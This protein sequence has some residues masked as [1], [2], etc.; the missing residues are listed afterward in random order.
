MSLWIPESETTS[1]DNFGAFTPA[2][3][4]FD[5]GGPRTFT[6]IALDGSL[7]LA[8]QCDEEDGQAGFLVTP[9]TADRIRHLKA[10]DA[11]IYD[12]LN[13]EQLWYVVVGE[14]ER[15]RVAYRIAFGDVPAECLPDPTVTLKKTAAKSSPASGP[16]PDSPLALI[17]KANGPRIG[18]L[19]V[20]TSVVK[21]TASG[22]YSSL[23]RIVDHLSRD[24]KW[25]TMSA[26]WWKQ[27]YDLPA[28]G[29]KA[30]SFEI[31]FGWPT[32]REE[33]A[34]ATDDEEQSRQQI[35]Q[36]ISRMLEAGIKWCA[37]PNPDT[38]PGVDREEGRVILEAIEALS[39]PQ[40]GSYI[41]EFHVGGGLIRLSRPVVLTKATRKQIKLRL[42]SERSPTAEDILVAG[43][44][45]KVDRGLQQL[46]VRRVTQSVLLGKTSTSGGNKNG[47]F[48]EYEFAYEEEYSEQVLDALENESKVYLF[49]RS[50]PTGMYTLLQLLK[51][52]SPQT[53]NPDN[54]PK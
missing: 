39:P 4:I 36:E 3:V 8:H 52:P 40:S 51:P 23:K 42:D 50:R 2:D 21:A 44:I 13:Q 30:A 35:I 31:R 47:L 38:L 32:P 26:D 17:L 53:K 54:P 34:K 14:T 19:S 46:T 27:F 49:G 29:F 48:P 6:L 9:V 5:F 22:A 20:P 28:H 24:S 11:G 25:G 43:V 37:D 41:E 45:E 16:V 33:S 10:G 18:E 7:L 12:T 15:P 1:T